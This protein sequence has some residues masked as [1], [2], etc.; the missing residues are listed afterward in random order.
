M[1]ELCE[2]DSHSF[3]KD[4]QMWLCIECFSAF[5]GVIVDIELDEV[6]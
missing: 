3:D 6:Y 5:N 1:C 2:R 4:M